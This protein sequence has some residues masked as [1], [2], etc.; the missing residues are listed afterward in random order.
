[1]TLRRI[2]WL[3]MMALLTALVAATAPA[4]PQESEEQAEP[5][6][7][8][9]PNTEAV[10]Q[11]LQQ[12]EAMLTGARFSYDP[13]GRRDPFRSLMIADPTKTSD[14]RGIECMIIAEI[15]LQLRRL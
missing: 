10:E 5:P 6:A 7:E 14:C 4:F 3:A 13:A 2:T 8:G 15:D 11:I 1:M 9:Q 12:Q